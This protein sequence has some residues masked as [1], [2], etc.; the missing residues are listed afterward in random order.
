MRIIQ[1][2]TACLVVQVLSVFITMIGLTCMAG[3]VMH[4]QN[5][6]TWA[7]GIGMAYPTAICLFLIGMCLFI[8]AGVM[9][10]NESPK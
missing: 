6:Y 7:S 4:L 10:A 3:H 2:K 8:M 5:L 1:I 9:E